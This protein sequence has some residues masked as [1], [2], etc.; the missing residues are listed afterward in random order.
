MGIGLSRTAILR[1]VAAAATASQIPL[2]ASSARADAPVKLTVMTDF[3]PWALGGPIYL[4]HQKGWFDAAGLDVT[5]S[6]GSGSGS[7]S[8]LVGVGRFDVGMVSLATAAIGRAKGLPIV[9]VA[10]L[11]RDSD[12]ALIYPHDSKIHSP[13][14]LAGKTIIFS[15]GGSEAPFIKTFLASGGL[16]VDQV[17]MLNLAPSAKDS[18]YAAGR[19]DALITQLPYSLPL[20]SSVR[21]SDGLMFGDYGVSL[22][23]YGL[24][25]SE[26]GLKA[27]GAHIGKF[28]SIV[29][30]AWEYVLNAHRD[31]MIRA[32]IAERPDAKL[33][34]D[35]MLGQFDL[36]AQRIEKTRSR[37]TPFGYANAAR[38]QTALSTLAGAKLIPDGLKATDFYTNAYLDTATIKGVAAGHPV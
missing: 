8:Q 19:A 20:I 6:D 35:V 9:A 1:G 31:E 15:T 24:I 14:D 12:T 29:I 22:P 11:F 5:I 13:K 23:G 18:T 30:G 21:P 33:K 27:G 10:Q 25:A 32:I 37:E 26:T 4:A 34:P 3:L 28:A 38:W 36:L 16:T 17:S 7:T 2:S